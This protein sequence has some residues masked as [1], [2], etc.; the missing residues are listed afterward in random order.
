MISNKQTN[1]QT[2]LMVRSNI[3]F[4]TSFFQQSNQG[5]FSLLSI[6]LFSTS[7][8]SN[9][10]YL[11]FLSPSIS[12]F[13]FET[14]SFNISYVAASEFSRALL[15]SSTCSLKFVNSSVHFFKIFKSVSSLSE[16][17]ALMASFNFG[18]SDLENFFKNRLFHKITSKVL[19]IMLIP[20]A[21]ILLSLV[22]SLLNEP[23][24]S[25]ISRAIFDSLSLLDYS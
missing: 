2:I 16:A 3:Q 9:T 18:K 24:L 21:L 19:L 20:S 15:S 6:K 22:N 23:N 8:I 25:S 17:V 5:F 13:I 11:S 1:K 4:I 12:F 10:P 14:T 7:N